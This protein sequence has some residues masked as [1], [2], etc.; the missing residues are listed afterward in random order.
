MLPFDCGAQKSGEFLLGVQRFDANERITKKP[1]PN[2]VI[3]IRII[4]KVY[5]HPLTVELSDCDR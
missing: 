1:A 5:N 2:A 3:T 4:N